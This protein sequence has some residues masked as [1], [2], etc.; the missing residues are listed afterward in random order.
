MS[1]RRNDIILAVILLL[2][3]VAGF[4][5]Y[6]SLQTEGDFVVVSVDNVT[7]ARFSLSEDTEYKINGVSGCNTLVIKDGKADITLADCPDGICANH[8]PVSKVGDAIV[9]LP[10]RVVVKIVS[11][12]NSQEEIDMVA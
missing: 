1:K 7:V 6:K 3:S 9:C 4:L 8:A 12:K 11:G 10:H 2:V 5:L